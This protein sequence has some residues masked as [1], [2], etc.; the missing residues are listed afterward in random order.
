MN[1]LKIYGITENFKHMFTNR[2]LISISHKVNDMNGK[3][4]IPYNFENLNIAIEIY[5]ENIEYR[6]KT[7]KIDLLEYSSEP[8]K[9]L[10]KLVETFNLKNDIKIIKEWEYKFGD[11]LLL[12]N[13]STDNLLIEQRVNDSWNGIINE[14]WDSIKK[15]AEWV[16]GNIKSGLD[17]AG[18]FVANQARELQQKGLG[19]YVASKAKS[20]WESVKSGIA[21]AW[22]CVKEGIG[23]IMEGLR[24]ITMSAAG[25]AILTGVAMIPKVGL[26]T[27]AIIFG[28]LLIWD[29]YKGLSGKGW[30]IVNIIIDIVAIV[31]PAAGRVIKTAAVGVNL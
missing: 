14:I 17:S 21:K 30:D 27:N 2:G 8:R 9:F 24:K 4:F 20:V 28:T 18:K 23:C 7:G 22:N 10:Y 31:L 29:I 6:Y 19:G 13:E 16:G 12:I 15:G 11:N 1:N 3:T 25:A 5:K 26:V